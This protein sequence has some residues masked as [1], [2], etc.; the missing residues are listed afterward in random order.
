M[1]VKVSISDLQY[2]LKL[3]RDV[4]P[5]QS[6]SPGGSHLKA[7]NNKVIFSSSNSELLVKTTIAAA[8]AEEGEV[9]V[10]AASMSSAFSGLKPK[11]EDGTG[12]SDVVLRTSGTGKKLLSSFSIS[13][14]DDQEVP[15][16]R[17]FGLFQDSLLP[18]SPHIPSEV[19]A[20]VPA[21]Q[22]IDALNAVAYALSSNKNF[23]MFTGVFLTLGNGGITTVG[24]DGRCLAEYTVKFPYEG[25]EVSAIVPGHLASRIASGFFPHEFVNMYFSDRM[26]YVS[27]PNLT[28]AG[29]LINEKYPDYKSILPTCSAFATVNKEVLL[30]T[31]SSLAPQVSK[32]DHNRVSFVFDDGTLSVNASGSGVTGIP[33]DFRGTQQFDCNLSLLMSSIRNIEGDVRV[34]FPDKGKTI[35][36]TS[37]DQ[38]FDNLTAIIVPLAS[39]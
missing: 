25:P 37:S 31:L 13:Y 28:I 1:K 8:C 16:R 11:K 24:S 36:F 15:H 26:L 10:D 39:E 38:E 34:W 5:K 14:K 21:A 33:T 2:A 29:P 27:S 3:V 23:V 17:S 18:N 7:E 9:T 12:A 20:R 22:L 35:K 19:T 4:S 30:D 32:E 6:D